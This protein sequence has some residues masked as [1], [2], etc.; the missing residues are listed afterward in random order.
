MCNGWEWNIYNQNNE[1]IEHDCSTDHLD[2]DCEKTYGEINPVNI[3]FTFTDWY[4][5]DNFTV[6]TQETI[7]NIKN[8]KPKAKESVFLSSKEGKAIF[9]FGNVYYNI[10]YEKCKV[11]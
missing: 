6:I 1:L 2:D 3:G 8:L 4:K 5:W 11:L 10:Q 9:M 7:M